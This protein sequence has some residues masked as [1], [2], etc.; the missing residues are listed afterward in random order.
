MTNNP[1][2]L[3]KEKMAEIILK[4]TALE[5]EDNS[6]VNLGFGLPTDLSIY[7]KPE[8]E[9][10]FHG[11]NGIL[12]VGRELE[13]EEVVEM[14][15]ISPSLVP[16]EPVKGAAFFDSGVSFGMIRGGHIDTVVLGTM[17]VDEKGNIANYA[18]PGRLTGMGGAMDLCVGTKKVIVTTYHTQRGQPKI[19]KRCTLPLT[20]Q[21]AVSTI[22]TEKAVIDVT[23][24]GL[25]LRKYNPAFTL[26]EIQAETE[27]NLLVSDNLEEMLV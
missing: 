4:N 25:L 20:A 24:K 27:A 10:L 12:G 3:D 15:V 6:I 23:D 17:E 7:I 8:Q 2:V 22:V 16:T 19:L 1:K 9:V 21:G 5:I 18:V 13:P 26:E 14:D 11:E